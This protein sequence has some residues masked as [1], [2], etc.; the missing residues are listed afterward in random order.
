M[1]LSR[2]RQVLETA[3]A[4]LHRTTGLAG[5]IVQDV[6]ELGHSVVVRIGSEN[7]AQLFT[8]EVRPVDR[9]QTPALVKAHLEGSDHMPL[10]IAPYITRETAEHCRS[11]QLP[12]VDT[13]GN[14]FLC[15]R[16]L[17][18]YVV[19]QRRPAALRQDRFQSMNAA[20]LR[21]TF[22]FLS[23]P[24]LL[25]ATH[26]EI[27]RAAT[28]S[29]GAVGPVMR[30]LEQ[31]GFVR[32]EPHRRTLVDPDRLLDEWVTHF[33]ISLR[34]K[35]ASRR[36]EADATVLH[37]TDLSKHRAWWGGE[38]AAERL[39]Q[40]LRPV[41]FTIYT[42]RSI[43]RLVATCRLSASPIGNIEVLDSFW[44]FDPDPAHLDVVH[45]ILAY[46]DL[47]A[48]HDGRNIEAAKLI[49][50]QYIQPVFERCTL[51]C[52]LDGKHFPGPI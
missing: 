1:M 28:T 33:P 2:N 12:F 46:A 4:E 51:A 43:N 8:V 50:Q 23:H 44:G 13:A 31:R 9:F 5:T 27:A 26:R 18:V 21:I 37:G 15:A 29:L 45:P 19:G 25:N 24:D 16:G 52:K 49:Y 39:T 22:V 3:L 7:E 14:A 40:Y 17:Y 20:G 11:I 47:L 10:L 42:E 6:P 38:A 36:F 34:P 41:T 35:L 48:T 32:V 30:D